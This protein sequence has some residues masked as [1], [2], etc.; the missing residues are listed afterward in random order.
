MSAHLKRQKEDL[1]RLLK[2]G[3]D[4]L[5]DL[6][7]RITLERT[8]KLDKES[9]EAK[10]KVDGTFENHYQNWYTKGS[11]LL[12]QLVPDRLQECISLQGH[13]Q[14][15]GNGC[16]DIHHPRLALRSEGRHPV[17]YGWV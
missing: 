9:T 4:M 2:L 16:H 5:L 8:K 10:K 11:A 3:H 7:F 1:E 17:W 15:Q 6:H 14:A 13:R 12:R